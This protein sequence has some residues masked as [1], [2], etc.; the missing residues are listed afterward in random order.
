MAAE[1]SYAR[2]RDREKIAGQYL[3]VRSRV[4]ELSVQG[5]LSFS[6]LAF[7]INTYTRISCA[8]YRA[9]EKQMAEYSVIFFSKVRLQNKSWGSQSHCR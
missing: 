1:S 7:S 2:L 4:F 5:V 3:G 8:I 9:I 6:K